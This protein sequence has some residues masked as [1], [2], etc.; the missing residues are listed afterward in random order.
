[1][2]GQSSTRTRRVGSL[3]AAEQAGYYNA[4]VTA[5]AFDAAEELLHVGTED[6]RMTVTHAPGLERYAGAHVHP[7]EYQ[8]ITASPLENAHGG[9]VTVS[10][11]RACY[12][13]GGCVKRWTVGERQGVDPTANPLTCGAVD[14]H[15]LG[16]SG[17]AYVGR[18]SA[19]MLQIDIGVGRVLA[20]RRAHARHLLAGHVVHRH[21]RGEGLV[22]CGGFGGELVMRDPRNKLRAETQL[23]S[24]AHAAGVTAVAAKGDLVITCGLTADRAGVV[25]V[26]PFVK[27]V[28]VRV[29]CR[30]LNVLQFPAGAVAVASTPSSTAPSCWA[31]RAGSCRRRTPTA[32]PGEL[33][34]EFFCRPPWI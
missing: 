4:P 18:S 34:R 23:S 28:D 2:E 21:G 12:T 13:S 7:R 9:V 1:M 5:L 15:Q 33:R 17:R 10:A 27:V 26:D 8:A 22:A 16:G 14:T 32:A 11:A 20:H 29:G 25:S 19:E 6:G 24:P 31:A 30:V 3:P